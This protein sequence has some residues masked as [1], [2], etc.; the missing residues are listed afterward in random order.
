MSVTE[1]D[2][3]FSAQAVL[4]QPRARIGLI[5]PA[6]NRVS[7]PQFNHFAPPGLG[8][9]VT[10]AQIAGKWSRPLA[11]LAGE[12]TK[13]TSALA[14]CAPDIIVYHCT[15]SSMKEGPDGERRILE[16]MRTVT[17]IEAVSTSALVGEAL[18][19]LSIKSVVLITPYE[20]NADVIAYLQAI[21]VK[22]VHDVALRLPAEQF[23]S[24]TP[25]RWFEIAK[26]N[27]RADADA[28]FLSC[29]ATRQIEAIAAIEAALNKPVVNSNQAV[30]WGCVK[31]L[32]AKLGPLAPMPALGRLMRH[33]D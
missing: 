25:Q 3:S 17:D 6:V 8:I 27:D 15:A 31:R 12:I 10:R 1:T 11:E 33:L 29:T 21:G 7:E 30:L 28:I 2:A 24:V 20:S 16:T 32:K 26:D 9:H 4:P 19:A 14:E 18:R 5:I 13:T 23:A 22:V